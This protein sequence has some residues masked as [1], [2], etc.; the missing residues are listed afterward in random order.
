MKAIRWSDNDNY[1]GPFTYCNSDYKRIAFVLGSGND[2]Y[3]RCRLRM[4]VWRYTLIIALPPVIKPWREK[5]T[6]H[7]WDEATVKRLGRNWYWNV[8][9][10]E[11]GFSY[12][13]GFLQVFHG[14]QTFDSSTTQSWCKHLPWTQWRHVRHSLYGLNG[15]HYW[16]FPHRRH[17]LGN[18]QWQ[19]DKAI[20][21][22]CPVRKFEFEDYDGMRIIATT[23]IEEREWHFGE[24][25]FK[26]LSIFRKPKISRSLDLQFSE[27]VGP[28][29]GSWKGGTI[30]HSIEM[31][32]GELHEAAFRR[33]CEKE[34]RAKS[35]QYKIKYIGAA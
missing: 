7:S 26:W 31:L 12:R 30:G 34:H 27:E 10:R 22:G 35:R 13:D 2:E 1:F 16:T 9:E 21:D 29:K 24:G 8:H 5:V 19:K 32:P 4:Q 33:Y 17:F 18:D 15:E 6:A 14:R 3:P 23:K 11:Y 25:W 20:E 28:E